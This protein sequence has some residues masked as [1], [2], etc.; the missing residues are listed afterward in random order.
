MIEEK[1]LLFEVSEDIIARENLSVEFLSN[2]LNNPSIIKGTIFIVCSKGS[3][4]VTLNHG[5]YVIGENDYITLLN[6]SFIQVHHVSP[7]ICISC[8]GFSLAIMHE[9]EFFKK[10]FD[11]LFIIFE[12]PVRHVSEE[13]KLYMIRSISLWKM[14]RGVPEIYS[15]KKVLRSML[16]TCIQT[17]I[18]MYLQDNSEE[19][20]AKSSKKLKMSR[21]FLKLVTMHYRTER[22][23]A[24]YAQLLGTS[25]ENLCRNIKSCTNMTPLE[26]IDSVIMMDAKSQLQSTN[27]SIKEIGISLGFDN[28]ATFCRFFRKHMGVSPL[29]YRDR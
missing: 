23:I 8:A 7:D 2:Y 29:R 13:L 11:Y 15:N 20:W 19:K 27:N 24:Y 10:A 9:I 17:S 12:K 25:K 4:E 3:M 6:N 28:L 16:D 1:E 26:V 21:H 5:R 22:G 14:I 18:S